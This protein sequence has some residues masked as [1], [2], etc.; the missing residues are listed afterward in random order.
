M[1]NQIALHA[2]HKEL[3][4]K[5][6]SPFSAKKRIQYRGVLLDLEVEI[7]NAQAAGHTLM[8]SFDVLASYFPDKPNRLAWAA[9][10]SHVQKE[11][12]EQVA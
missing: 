11:Q 5:Y 2:L 9:A 8:E 7:K 3:L 10:W 6:P 4:K 12:K 1:N